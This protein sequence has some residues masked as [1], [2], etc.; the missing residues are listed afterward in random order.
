MHKPLLICLIISGS[1]ALAQDASFEASDKYLREESNARACDGFTAFLKA[2]PDSPLKREAT[3]KRAKACMR[4]GRSGN[5]YQELQT[6]ATTGEKDFARAYACTVNAEQGYG[7]FATCLPLLK[8]AIGD[9]R[10]GDEARVLFVRGAFRDLDNYTYDKKRT[11]ERVGEILE[12]SSKSGE[13]ARARLY[14]ARFNLR[15]P[16]TFAEGERESREL[17]E[18][19]SDVADDAL[20]ELGQAYENQQKF[21]P[22]LELYDAVVKRFSP[23][24]SNVRESA[25]S[26]AADIRRPSASISVS[27]IEIPGTK[28][29]VGFSYRNVANASW[30]V[31]RVD[32]LQLPDPNE[33]ISYEETAF[34]KA[35]KETVSTWSAKLT[36][37]SKHAHGSSTFDLDLKAPGAYLLEVDADGQRDQEIVLITPHATVMKLERDQALTFTADALTGAGVPNA[38]VVLYANT[39]E[40]SGYEKLT[41]KADATGVARFDLKGKKTYQAVAW[42]S[43]AGSYSYTRGYVGGWYQPSREHLGYVVTDR[44]LFK[45]GESVGFKVFLRSRE[46]GPSVPLANV[47]VQLYVRDPS[48]RELAKPDLVTNAFGTA[49]FTLPLK[50]D[51]QLGQYYATLSVSGYSVNQA[52][53]NFRVEEYKP[54]EYTVGVAPV[55]KPELGKKLK[56]KVSASFFFGGP[57]ANASGRAIV[58]VRYWQHQFG[59]WGDEPVDDDPYGYGSPYANR[60]RRGGYYGGYYGGGAS[61]TLQFKTGADGTAEVEVPELKPEQ[62]AGWP[63]IEYAVQV[64]VTDASRREVTGSGS[65]KTSREPYFVDL[66]GDRFLYKPGERVE[67]TLRAEDAN[68]KAEDPELFVRLVRVVQTGAASAIAK[69]KVKLSGGRGSLKLDADALGPVR[70]EARATDADDA[71]VLAQADVWLTNDAKPMMPEGYGFQLFTD[72]APLKV[73]QMVRALVVAPTAGGHVLVTIENERLQWAKAL[74]LNGR[75]KFIEVPL[76]GDMAPNSWLHVYRFEQAVPMQNQLE[77]RVKGSEVELP[78]KVAFAKANTEPGTTVPLTVEAPG[79]PKGADSEIAVTVVDEALYA[80]EGPRTDFLSFFGR[81]RREQ[82]VQ[83]SSSMQHKSYRRPEP[84]R[85]KTAQPQQPEAKPS[86]KEDAPSRDEAGESAGRAAP[87][88]PATSAPAEPS[89]EKAMVADDLASSVG[90][91]DKAP[92][93]RKAGGAGPRGGADLDT[94][95]AE[96]PVKVRTDFGSSSGWFASIAAKAGAA[97]SQDVQLKDSLTSWRATAY[98]VTNGPHLGVGQGNIRTEKPLMV[99]LQAPRFFTERDEVTLSAIVVSR[100]DKP[101]EVDVAISAPGLKALGPAQ[102]VLKVPAGEDVR[103]DVRFQVVDIGERTV[104]AVAK[105]GALADAMEWKLPSMVH[106]SAQ[107]KAF[108]GRLGDKF[109]LEL[110]LPEK[111]KPQAT[112]FELTLSPSLLSVMFDG[113]PYLAQYPYGCV[114]QTLSRFVPAAIARRAVKDLNLPATRVPPQLDD[115][116]DAGLKRLYGFQHS[117]GGW[118]WWQSDATNKWMSAY[119]VYGL[120]LGREAGL[121]I[122]GSVLERGRAYLNGVLGAARNEPETQAFMT[123][124]L[125]STG[126]APKSALDFA[127]GARTK[128]SPRG[129]ALVALALLA[130]KDPRARIAVENLDDVVKA[131]ASRPDAAVGEVNDAWSTSAAIEATAYTLMAMA[132]YDLKSP[133]L[134][135]LTDFLVLRR[136]GGKWRTTRDTAF[137]I[138]ALS[139]LARREEASGKSGGFVVL[140]NGREVKRLTFTKGGIDLTAPVVL[141]DSAFKAGKNVVEV[142]Q[143]GAAAT[144]YFAAMFDVFNQNDFIKGVGGDVVVTRKYTLLG[145]PSD[146]PGAAPTEYGM[147]L[148]SG[149]RVRVDLEV[150]AN[151]AVEFVMIEDLKPAGLEA[152]MLK[153]GPEVCNYQCAHAE[154]RTDRVA[155]FLQQIP[156]GVTKLSYELRAEVPGK[157]AALPA[158]AE[159]MYAPE[160]QA[161]SDEMRFEVRDAAEGNVAGR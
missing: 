44:P 38:D 39:N 67:V 89:A 128:L 115:M 79:A 124:A 93:K 92:A 126:G 42:V 121:T 74:E 143:D 37:P 61:H 144:G 108:A 106:G 36:V 28:P 76:T 6:M 104:K 11:M 32:P 2:N 88:P 26:R 59:P 117:D 17:G 68:G 155:M 160:I 145:K 35:A 25:Q 149:T 131:A 82:R 136:N 14:R 101:A 57:V 65:I 29:Q 7:D 52:Q 105:S 5:W 63:G 54:P 161:T 77:I 95:L 102:K 94:G 113:L 159:A 4:V 66:R 19:G 110:E 21:V 24:T 120:G 146:Q 20:Y 48:G 64:F 100:L 46:D 133:N 97:A 83:T 45:P 135:P 84:P 118:G 12:V 55:G 91:K 123:Y 18:G 51:A 154:L 47:K 147:P 90:A 80:I 103:F 78:V 3:A 140:V 125:A 81:K 112:R 141:D 15:E 73:G 23:Q 87:A 157:F 153:S 134:K 72:R 86:K 142:R 156:V 40:G 27:Y 16:K 130:A 152:V 75:A 60:Y 158:R 69:G 49:H 85:A 41:A 109:T 34:A 58:Q 22:A 116:V 33:A 30:K 111:R 1:T 8:Q 43:G 31:R 50:A 114:E 137:A 62:Y 98:V 129:R 53:A 139:D 119:V 127:F 10:V 151:K 13:K 107:R 150:K 71:P 138:Y 122:D 56:F 70:I 99:R 9:G 148:E 132:R 96:A